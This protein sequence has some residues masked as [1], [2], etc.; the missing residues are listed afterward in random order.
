MLDKVSMCG[1]TPCDDAG[2]PVLVPMLGVVAK[3]SVPCQA[4]SLSS[5]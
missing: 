5:H 2:N 4:G 1:L 3:L